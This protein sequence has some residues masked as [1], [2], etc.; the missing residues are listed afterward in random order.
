LIGH[1]DYD[2]FAEVVDELIDRLFVEVLHQPRDEWERTFR[3]IE[4]FASS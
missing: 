2:R 4:P 1:I 3:F